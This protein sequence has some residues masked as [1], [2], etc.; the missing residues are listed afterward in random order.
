MTTS[1][2]F[3]FECTI[4]CTYNQECPSNINKIQDCK[5]YIWS[6]YSCSINNQYKCNSA[7][8]KSLIKNNNQGNDVYN[9][10]KNLP[11]CKN[12][13]NPDKKNL[14]CKF[15]EKRYNSNSKKIEKYNYKSKKFEIIKPKITPKKTNNTNYSPI[16]SS[17]PFRGVY[18]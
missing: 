12:Y 7:N 17:N 14:I 18:R 3:K 13:T 9:F 16:H 11:L 4:N 8:I 2:K 15:D 6:N 1:P 5:E 10:R